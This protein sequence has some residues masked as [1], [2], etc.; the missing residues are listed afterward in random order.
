[1]PTLGNERT[2]FDTHTDLN[3]VTLLVAAAEAGSITEA[4]RRTGIRSPTLSRQ[5]RKLED[6]LGMGLLHR[7]PSGDAARALNGLGVELAKSDLDDAASLKRARSLA[8]RSEPKARMLREVSARCAAL[9]SRRAR[10]QKHVLVRL[11]ELL[12]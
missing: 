4:A 9:L 5:L 1:M 7:G 11:S 8:A 6:E 12:C 10:D 2:R 3:G